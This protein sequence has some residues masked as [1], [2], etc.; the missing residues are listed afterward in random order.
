MN[1]FKDEISEFFI[2]AV[3]IFGS[4]GLAAALLF[5]LL[6][7][8]CA[9]P[10]AWAWNALVPLVPHLPVVG[11]KH[12]FAFYVLIACMKLSFTGIKVSTKSTQDS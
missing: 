10:L 11:W 3:A 6:A 2:A 9:C 8:V 1:N 5:I 7:A 4:I 12:A